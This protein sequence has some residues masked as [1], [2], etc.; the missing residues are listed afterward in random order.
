MQVNPGELVLFHAFDHVFEGVFLIGV[1]AVGVDC[2]EGNAFVFVPFR[3]LARH[4]I[5]ANDVGAVVAGEKDYQVL[6]VGKSSREYVRPSVAG[7]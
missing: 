6:G 2:H 5:R 1:G 7:D 3:C 4:F